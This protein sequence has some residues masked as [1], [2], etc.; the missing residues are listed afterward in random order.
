M[1]V[2]A[3]TTVVSNFASISQLH[4]LHQLF[5]ALYISTEVYEEIQS[6]L[7]E[8]YQFYAGIDQMTHPFV[9]DGW[10]RLTSMAHEAEIGLYGELPSHLHQGEA[11][12]LV[13][14]R[15]R[16]WL[17]LTDDRA[18]RDEGIRLGIMVSGSLGCL[19][20][21]VTIKWPI[22]GCHRGGLSHDL[23]HSL[24]GPVE[25]MRMLMPFSNEWFNLGLQLIF[26]CKV[27][28]FQ[29]F[30]LQNAEPLFD[31]IHPRAMH[32]REVQ[33]QARMLGEPLADLLPMMCADMVAHEMHHRA[34]LIN[35]AVQLVQKSHAF[36]LTFAIRTRPIDL[37]GAG[38]KGRKEM[39][40]PGRACTRARIDGEGA[41]V[42]PA[43]VGA[44]GDEAVRRSSHPERGR[45]HPHSVGAYRAR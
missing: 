31:L 43:G 21:L 36:L 38:I 1:S 3:N 41:R 8:G 7:E 11:S 2:I 22:S 12:C 25:R 24:G 13:I 44:D 9:H 29:P 37:A 26:R 45:S 32:G 4:L 16:G 19:V 30:T 6:G 28:D 42:G 35:L 34:V 23:G 14:A 27:G 15:Q 39:A 5:G 17:L 10:I 40:R 20:Q 18:A 33:D